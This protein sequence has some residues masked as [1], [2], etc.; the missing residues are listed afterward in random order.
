MHLYA[1]V[2][3]EHIIG[4]EARPTGN[5]NFVAGTMAMY[6]LNYLTW[7]QWYQATC[8]FNGRFSI[9]GTDWV[10][11]FG[12]TYADNSNHSTY[13]KY[14]LGTYSL[15]GPDPLAASTPG[16]FSQYTLLQDIS[17]TDGTRF[18]PYFMQTVYFFNR[19]LI[20]SGGTSYVYLR[21]LSEDNTKATYSV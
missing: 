11:I 2:A 13:Y 16:A 9:L 20:L 3:N 19:H 14:L 21:N 6:E 1:E 12:G 17:T 18:S 10:T 15:Y 7:S 5:P 8:D 4:I